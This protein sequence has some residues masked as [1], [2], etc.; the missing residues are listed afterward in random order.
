MNERQNMPPTSQSIQTCHRFN[1]IRWHDSEL[2][3]VSVNH[4]HTEPGSKFTYQVILRVDLSTVKGDPIKEVFLPIEVRFLH[5]RY[6]QT[7]LDLLGV[8]Y[9]GG[10]ISHGEC[11]EDSSFKRQIFQTRIAQFDL[12]QD[13]SFWADLK[14]FHVY[15]CDPSGQ[16]NVIAEDFEIRNLPANNTNDGRTITVL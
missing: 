2:R 4:L 9:C 1:E 16:I 13:V 3:S 15:L 11:F 14:H 6:F 8:G 10:D 12:P 5:A 7:D